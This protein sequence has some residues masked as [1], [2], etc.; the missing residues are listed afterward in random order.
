M[1]RRD[2]IIQIAIK[3]FTKQG[4]HATSIRQIAAGVGCRESAIYVHFKNGKRELL[5]TILKHHMPDFDDILSGCVAETASEHA[6]EQLGHHLVS[7]AET[8]LQDWLWIVGEFPTLKAGERAIVREKLAALH[9]VLVTHL[10]SRS[11]STAEAP[12][13]AWAFITMLSGY[14][15]LQRILAPDCPIE[16]SRHHFIS[17]LR[18]LMTETSAL[19]EQA[20]VQ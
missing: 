5:Q 8:H 6:L 16:F 3:L 11:I 20:A 15:Q 2:D 1:N 14:A 19:T 17:V 12:P 10:H 4:Y 7:L 18:L 9:Q 13:L